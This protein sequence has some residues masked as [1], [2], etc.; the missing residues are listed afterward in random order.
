MH[1]D[2]SQ[3][4]HS[5]LQ[6]TRQLM[7]V[8]IKASVAQD[9]GTKEPATQRCLQLFTVFVICT[10]IARAALLVSLVTV[11]EQYAICC[12]VQDHTQLSP[13]T[14]TTE[15]PTWSKDS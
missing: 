7:S 2:A 6:Q 8:L 5:R 4:K 11:R 9:M 1:R 10:S 12:W 3:Y 14:V 15:P 13:S